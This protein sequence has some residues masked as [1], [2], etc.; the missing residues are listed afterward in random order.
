MI[1]KDLL[2]ATEEVLSSGNYI[3]GE[4]VKEFEEKFASYC[5]VS[6]AIAVGNGS[7]GLKLIMKSI[8][9]D[10]NDEVICPANSFIASAWAIVDA[11]AKPVFCDVDND[12]LLSVET[13]KKCIT[14]RTKAIM[15]VHLTGKLCDNEKLMDY[16][17]KENILF[18]EDAAQA[19]GAMNPQGE[20]AGTFGIAESFSMH[21]L[22]NLSLYGDGGV[23]TTNSKKVAKI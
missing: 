18:I 9:L 17:K 22:K 4:K 7:D 6:D 11:G 3:L 2:D 5:G 14:D 1:K 19:V 15:A 20:K 16:C 12:L 13:I 10:K 23:V 21:P 8:G